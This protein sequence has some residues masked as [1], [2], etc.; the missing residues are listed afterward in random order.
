MIYLRRCEEEQ[1]KNTLV[2]KVIGVSI[3][4]KV[5]IIEKMKI[6]AEHVVFAAEI[7][8]ADRQYCC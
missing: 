7:N 3:I 4:E 1:R 2:T 5:K 8:G 6:I